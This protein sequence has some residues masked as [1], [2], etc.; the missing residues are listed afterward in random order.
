M[1]PLVPN[2]DGRVH[3]HAFLEALLQRASKVSPLGRPAG[4]VVVGAG[5]VDYQ[6]HVRSHRTITGLCVSNG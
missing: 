3:F 6:S 2:A 4:A 5:P 1:L